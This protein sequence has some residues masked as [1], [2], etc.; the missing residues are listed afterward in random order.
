MAVD[1]YINR[2]LEDAYYD[3]A[4]ALR[5]SGLQ[6]GRF[7]VGLPPFPWPNPPR[8]PHIA[9]VGR[10]FPRN[11]LGTDS[12]T[13][14]TVYQRLFN[15][16]VKI[17]PAFESGLFGVPGG[18]A[19]LTKIERIQEDGTPLPGK[20]RW[21]KGKIP[22]LSLLEYIG[23][24]FIEKPGYFRVIA[25]VITTENYRPE[26]PSTKPLPN[27]SDGAQDLPEEIARDQFKGKHGYVLIY[28]F[29]RKQGGEIKKFKIS[30]LSALVHLEKSG[31][32]SNLK[33]FP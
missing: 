22:P 32:L 28:S 25:F 8:P 30:S 19:M 24:L 9:V 18:F 31:I 16:L 2:Q 15:T 7:R 12:T 21:V 10:E 14:G 20:Y 29:K 3:I 13:L 17:D 23:R 5:P 1:S 11:L 33:I 27:I 6:S 26:R 4:E